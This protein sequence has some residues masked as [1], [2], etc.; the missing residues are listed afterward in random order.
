MLQGLWRGFHRGEQNARRREFDGLDCLVA[1][2]GEDLPSYLRL[3]AGLDDMG[4]DQDLEECF[5][6]FGNARKLIGFE[7]LAHVV[8]SVRPDDVQAVFTVPDTRLFG[9]RRPQDVR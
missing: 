6:C 1:M 5:G 7:E 9:I 8:S 4:V 2:R 3:A